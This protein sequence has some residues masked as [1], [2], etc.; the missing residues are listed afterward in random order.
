MQTA[1]LPLTVYVSQ[2]LIVAVNRELNNYVTQYEL[3]RDSYNSI[4]YM[5]Y[6]R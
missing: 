4:H 6:L 1:G 2:Q 5:E 3:K